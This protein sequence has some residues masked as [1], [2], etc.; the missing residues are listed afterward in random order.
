MK[1]LSVILPDAPSPKEKRAERSVVWLYL[2]FFCL[3]TVGLL[4][5]LGASEETMLGFP[6]W[7]FFSCIFAY[8][9]IC[10]LLAWVIRKFF[11]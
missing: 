6:L 2:V 1:R 4:L 8:S 10:L 11:R 7:F 9:C 5:G 3:W